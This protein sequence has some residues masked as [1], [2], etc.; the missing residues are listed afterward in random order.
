MLHLFEVLLESLQ[1]LPQL[2]GQTLADGGIEAFDI[3]GILAP[4]GLIDAEQLIQHHVGELLAVVFQ[5]L[6]IDILD[7]GQIADFGLAGADLAFAA[8]QDPQQNTHIIT[9][10]GP[11]EVA[12]IIG[13]EPTKTPWAQSRDW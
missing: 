10:A 6:D 5:T 2:G 12:F 4:Q 13:A 8:G 9:E 11:Q 1:L 3:L 7:I